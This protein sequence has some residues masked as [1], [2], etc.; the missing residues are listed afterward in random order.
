MLHHSRETP[1]RAACQPGPGEYVDT[2]ADVPEEKP[3]KRFCSENT[4]QQGQNQG[5]LTADVS[6]LAA[7]EEAA[8]DGEDVLQG[9]KQGVHQNQVRL[10]CRE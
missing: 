8:A 4:I 3:G 10:T 2:S 1:L 5:C 6:L 9:S 7:V